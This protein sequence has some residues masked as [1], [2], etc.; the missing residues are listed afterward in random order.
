MND[1]V[2]SS[3]TNRPA[4]IN[5]SASQTAPLAHARGQATEATSETTVVATPN[6]PAPDHGT[7]ATFDAAPHNGNNPGMGKRRQQPISDQLRAAIRDADVTV[8]RIAKSTGVDPA[9]LSKFLSGE[10]GLSLPTIDLIGEFLDVKLVARK[11]KEK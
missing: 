6:T 11:A 1:A 5:S 2:E 9:I 4:C 3:G 8:Y 10:R 7:K